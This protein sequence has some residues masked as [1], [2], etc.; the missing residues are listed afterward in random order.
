MEA[1][2]EVLH[3]E[4]H[5]RGVFSIKFHPD[6]SLACSAGLDGYGRIWDLRNGRCIMFMEGH[7]QELYDCDFNQNGVHVS[8]AS[9]DNTIKIWDLRQTGAAIKTLPAHQGLVTR[10]VFQ[11]NC[12]PASNFMVSASYDKTVKIWSA[13][14]Y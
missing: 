5:T 12:A 9:A 14:G 13:P 10:C 11:K 8:T 3:Q 2:E 1:G 6:G 4:G 7:T